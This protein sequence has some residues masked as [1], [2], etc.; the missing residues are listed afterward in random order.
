MRHAKLDWRL[1]ESRLCFE[2]RRYGLVLVESEIDIP[3]RTPVAILMHA[4]TRANKPMPHVSASSTVRRQSR[5]KLFIRDPNWRVKNFDLNMWFRYQT[6][7]KEIAINV[8]SML[9]NGNSILS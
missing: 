7:F 5:E 3:Y 1:S 8:Y 6:Y 9:R 2:V 4:C